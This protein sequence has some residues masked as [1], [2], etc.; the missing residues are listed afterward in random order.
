MYESKYSKYLIQNTNRFPDYEYI[1]VFGKSKEVE[2]EDK[3]EIIS[4]TH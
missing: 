1:D 2:L 3:K 4:I